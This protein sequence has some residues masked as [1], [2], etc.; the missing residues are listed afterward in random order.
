M[1]PTL[2]LP[3]EEHFSIAHV[4]LGE[5]PSPNRNF[6]SGLLPYREYT[7]DRPLMQSPAGGASNVLFLACLRPRLS[8]QRGAYITTK[9]VVT[10]APPTKKLTRPASAV[11]SAGSGTLSPQGRGLSSATGLLRRGPQKRNARHSYYF[12]S[13][14]GRSPVESSPGAFGMAFW[15]ICKSVAASGAWKV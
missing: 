2:G 3:F 12:L 15:M 14:L 1:A 7:P 8:I 6:H 11:E 13:G 10:Y 9:R 4:V 5:S